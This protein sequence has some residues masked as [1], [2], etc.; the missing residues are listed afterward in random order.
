MGLPGEFSLTTQSHSN[1]SLVLF[2]GTFH[3]HS[4]EPVLPTDSFSAAF[5]ARMLE[6]KNDPIVKAAP[7]K[8]TLRSI[9]SR[10]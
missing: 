4:A 1:V 5:P 9:K 6:L 2:L 3:M 7:L 8:R 10:N